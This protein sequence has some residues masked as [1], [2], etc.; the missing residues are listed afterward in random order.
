MHAAQL[1]PLHCSSGFSFHSSVL[2]PTFLGSVSSSFFFSTFTEIQ[3]CPVVK[4]LPSNAGGLD[5]ITV[6]K[7]RVHMP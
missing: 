5:S 1:L 7:L 2:S 3:L 4:T 6:G